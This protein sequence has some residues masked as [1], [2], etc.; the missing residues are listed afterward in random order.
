M[1]GEPRGFDYE[2]EPL[3]RKSDWELQSLRLALA[4]FNSEIDAQVLVVKQ[5]RDRLTVATED[6]LRQQ[7]RM[8]VIHIDKQTNAYEYITQLSQQ[9][10]HCKEVL[11]QLED[12]RD[13]VIKDL[14]KLQKFAD[15]LDEHREKELK[16]Y[17]QLIGKADIVEADDAWSRSSYWKA[18][19]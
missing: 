3:R 14:H 1:A 4:A 18:A 17:I 9:L 2:L 8:Q 19:Q 15:G 7:G 16:G 10:K 11:L 5:V 13:Q 6:H 12:K